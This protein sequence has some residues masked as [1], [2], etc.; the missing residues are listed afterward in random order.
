VAVH[1]T[2]AG[3][4]ASSIMWSIAYFIGALILLT[5]AATAAGDDPTPVWHRSF[6]VDFN[7]TTKLF[8]LTWKVTIVLKYIESNINAGRANAADRW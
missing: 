6:S 2:Q 1:D 5:S 4:T 7:E 3:T 8:L